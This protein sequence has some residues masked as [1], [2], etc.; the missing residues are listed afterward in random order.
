MS[1]SFQC[2]SGSLSFKLECLGMHSLNL[3]K[4]SKSSIDLSI[5][6]LFVFDD[7]VLKYSILIS[8]SNKQDIL[9]HF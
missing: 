6:M 7:N 5:I 2:V 9:V 4:F 1:V 8:F 3:F